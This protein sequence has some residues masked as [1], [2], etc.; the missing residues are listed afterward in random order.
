MKKD[1]RFIYSHRIGVEPNKKE[2]FN[3]ST[4][5]K[6]YARYKRSTTKETD[7]YQKVFYIDELSVA[8]KSAWV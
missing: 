6:Q 4:Q 7:T 8:S 1:Y 2:R 5:G 3:C